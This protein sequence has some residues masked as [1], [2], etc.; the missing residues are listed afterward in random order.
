[1][2]VIPRA[3]GSNLGAT[4]AA[5]VSDLIIDNCAY[6][7][8][9]HVHNQRTQS[10]PSNTQMLTVH[11]TGSKANA[12]ISAS[13]KRFLQKQIFSMYN[14]HTCINFTTNYSD[15]ICIIKTNKKSQT[16]IK[17]SCAFDEKKVSKKTNRFK[18]FRAKTGTR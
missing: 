10:Q 2:L 14:L 7:N 16:T 11:E 3:T 1:M 6:S 12:P 17:E 8:T 15:Q 4:Y 9:I 18:F 13:Q 5:K